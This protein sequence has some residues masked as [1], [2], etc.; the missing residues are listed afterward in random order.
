MSILIFQIISSFPSPHCVPMSF[1]Y[2]WV[3][4]PALQTGS[5]VPLFFFKINS[6]CHL[7]LKREEIEREGG[8]GMC[9]SEPLE[10]GS[11]QNWILGRCECLHWVKPSITHVHC[12]LNSSFRTCQQ[13]QFTFICIF[14][15]ISLS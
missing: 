3:A 11:S 14:F 15:G 13:L 1:F 12:T 7:P 4:S 10:M 5:S 6:E 9:Q 8:P 2:L